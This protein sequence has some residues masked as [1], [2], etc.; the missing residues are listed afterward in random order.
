MNGQI[1]SPRGHKYNR[2]FLQNTYNF[3]IV[4]RAILPF[5]CCCCSILWLQKYLVISEKRVNS[6]IYWLGNI[7]HYSQNSILFYKVKQNTSQ[8]QPHGSCVRRYNSRNDTDEVQLWLFY[9]G[10][11][12]NVHWIVHCF[13]FIDTFNEIKFWKNYINIWFYLF[14]DQ[15]FDIHKL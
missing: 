3:V 10:S 12:L 2:F 5:S 7:L 14:L 9:V 4:L 6:C 8:Y 11:W 1:I 13:I 15:K